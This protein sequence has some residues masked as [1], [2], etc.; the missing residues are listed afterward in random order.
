MEESVIETNPVTKA[1][2]TT[3][4]KKDKK[5][6]LAQLVASQGK[7][8]F[9]TQCL[10][11]HLPDA[12]ILC[13]DQVNTTA[14]D[15]GIKNCEKHSG[16]EFNKTYRALLA[17]K[18]DVIVDVGGAKECKE[19]L[20]GMLAIDGSDKITHFIVPSRPTSKDQGGAVDTIER[21]LLDGVDKNK[22][23]VIFTDVRK[24]VREEFGLL[25]AGMEENGIIPDLDLMIQHSPLYGEMIETKELISDILA[26]TTDYAAKAETRTK[27]DKTDY[28][29][30]HIRQRMA[31][32]TGWPNM[33]AVF[34]RLFPE[35]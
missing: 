20:D 35:G 6:V 1:V 10:H 13:V 29:G 24:D 33:Q 4:D 22:I 34:R 28:V 2:L 26:D 31:Q 25:I 21:L 15:F 32:R 19:F 11:P 3:L 5:I 12:R 14:A 17:T 27:G 30:K 23:K 7:T 18:G 9:V 8:M 16:D